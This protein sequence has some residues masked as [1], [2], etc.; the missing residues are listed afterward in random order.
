VGEA[1]RL[2]ERN[3]IKEVNT[4]PDNIKIITEKQAAKQRDREAAEEQ[5]ASAKKG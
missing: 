1:K 4:T 3:D 2:P 5:E